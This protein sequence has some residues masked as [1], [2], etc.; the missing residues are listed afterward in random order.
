[1]VRLYDVVLTCL[2]IAKPLKTMIFPRQNIAMQDRR[3]YIFDDRVSIHKL[4]Y[5]H[6][7]SGSRQEESSLEGTAVSLPSMQCFASLALI[8]AP[9]FPVLLPL[10]AWEHTSRP[11]NSWCRLE[12]VSDGEHWNKESKKGRKQI[13]VTFKTNTL[14]PIVAARTTLGPASCMNVQ[15]SGRN[16]DVALAEGG[17]K[18][19]E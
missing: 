10:L 4:G 16:A 7:F 1:M 18:L 11:Y 2:K 15:K 6:S 14:S 3:R 9:V 8:F 12:L 13:K 17:I 5:R 19:R